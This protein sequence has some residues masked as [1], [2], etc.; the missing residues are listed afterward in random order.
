M[1]KFEALGLSPNIVAAL[2]AKGFDTPTPIQ[3]QTIPILLSGKRDVIGQAQT[4]TGKTAAFGL[5]ILETIQAHQ[6][7]VQALIMT[8]T[9]EL[10]V[11]VRDEIKSIAGNRDLKI[12]TIYGGTPISAELRALREGADIVVG[13]PGRII[14]HLKRKSLVVS[15]LKFMVLDEADEMLNMGFYD[16]IEEILTYTNAE[17]QMLLFSATM[18]DRILTLAKKYM[19]PGYQ[20]VTIKKQAV[21]TD[22]TEQIFYEVRDTDK[23]EVLCRVI[24]KAPAF[25]GLVF[26]NT[27]AEVD[28]ITAKLNER[29][30]RSEAL[31]GDILQSQREKVLNKFRKKL[32]TVL[33]ATDVAARGIDVSNVTHVVN[34]DIP[35][36]PE[37]YVHRIGRTGRAGN[38]GIAI[39]FVS[40]AKLRKLQFIERMTKTQVKREKIPTIQDVINAKRE[41]LQTQ[42]EEIIESGSFE[43]YLPIAQKLLAKHSPESVAAALMHYSF[44]QQTEE[45]LYSEIST[46]PTGARRDRESSRFADHNNGEEVTLFVAVGRNDGL[47]PRKLV[48]MIFDKSRVYG[49]NINNIQIFNKH[50][51]ISVPPQAAN[52]ILEA[53]A[54]RRNHPPLIRMD[55]G[56]N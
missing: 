45:D 3:E 27:K 37:I 39:S 56:M 8:P 2:T 52:T 10:A 42:I 16:D 5:P 38:T 7:N 21:T 44:G 30:I 33:I 55:K 25:Y 4:G 31:H 36:D 53:F 1:N 46:P 13:T 54:P 47:N 29:G 35:Q 34:F 50:S 26:C 6:P 14:D 15:E 32:A 48:E 11:Q 40:P 18:P 19:R 23:F 17:K 41:R 12:M 9:R 51:L 20:V 49:R 24:D 43:T 22:L 28:A